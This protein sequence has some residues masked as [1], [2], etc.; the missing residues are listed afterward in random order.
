VGV[1]LQGWQADPY[2]L[3][4][5]RWFSEGM[6]TRLIRN[7]GVTG[8]GPIPEGRPSLDVER[9][10]PAA[11]QTGVETEYQVATA[12]GRTT[13]SEKVPD[14]KLGSDSQP[15]I[16]EPGWFDD[17]LQPIALRYWDGAEWTER[18][19]PKMAVPGAA[20]IDHHQGQP[21]VDRT[22]SGKRAVR[23]WTACGL[24]VLGIAM[25]LQGTIGHVR[26]VLPIGIIGLIIGV[27][28]LVIIFRS[29]PTQPH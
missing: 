5:Q 6:P 25:V 28:V 14:A 1:E 13:V 18:V 10:L 20:P 23:I 21:M 19:K 4:E 12:H 2:G 9:Q 27:G 29:K 3:H 8:Q 15:A 11:E 17:P 7:G 24:V 26:G 22:S 16:I